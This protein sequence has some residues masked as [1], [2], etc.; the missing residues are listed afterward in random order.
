MSSY[1]VAGEVKPTCREMMIAIPEKVWE[2]FENQA[3]VEL[4]QPLQMASQVKTNGGHHAVPC[5]FC[6]RSE[7]E[8]PL[9]AEG[10]IRSRP[11]MAPGAH[12]HR[13]HRSDAA[14]VKT[15][16]VLGT[17]PSSATTQL[18]FVVLEYLI[19]EHLL[20]LVTRAQLHTR[21]WT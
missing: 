9:A 5:P 10:D 7:R 16:R 11:P 1:D 21:A 14:S 4:S 12:G 17:G 3:D 19:K 13:L 15:R 20:G 6:G 8:P 18:L 2:T